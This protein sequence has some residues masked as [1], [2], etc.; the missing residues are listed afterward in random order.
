M[1]LHL[2][3]FVVAWLF[4]D[5]DWI[6]GIIA[7]GYLLL[8]A[9]IVRRGPGYLRRPVALLVFGLALLVNG[10]VVTPTAGWEWLLPLYYLKR[11]VAHLIREE[12]YR[13]IG[14]K[15]L[16]QTPKIEGDTTD[17]TMLGFIRTRL[18]RVT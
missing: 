3:P 16:G 2:H 7:Y 17:R 14:G 13:P 9:V 4:R 1:A 12:P 15:E 11:L 10:Y 18:F 8:A 6:C 5:G